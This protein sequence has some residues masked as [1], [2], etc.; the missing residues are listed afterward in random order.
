LLKVKKSAASS[1][2]ALTMEA[3]GRLITKALVEVVMLK[4]LPVVPVE[5]LAMMLV[6]TTFKDL[7]LLAASVIKTWE[8][9]VEAM[10][11]LPEGVIWKKLLPEVEAAKKTG[12]VWEEEE[13]VRAKVAAGVELLRVKVCWVLCQRKLA[14]P[15]VVEAAV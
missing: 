6:G 2:P 9:E 3:L 1:W 13:A 5:T 14:E 15:E 10:M 11:T 12:R 7:M 8:A 4:A